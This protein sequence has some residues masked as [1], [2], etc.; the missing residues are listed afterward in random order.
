MGRKTAPR[1]GPEHDRTYPDGDHRATNISMN[2]FRAESLLSAHLAEYLRAH[3]LTLGTFNVLMILRG[4][5][6]PLC[7]WE[8]SERRLVARGTMT[9]LL[10]SLEKRGLIERR[11]HPTDRRSVHV[12]ITTKALKLLEQLLPGFFAREATLFSNLSAREK[13]T[14]ISLLAKAQDG[15][16]PST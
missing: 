15:L 3:D 13:E 16:A 7:P 9:G 5:E 11:A 4:A 1:V 10:D 6:E 12:A 8:I 14:L 2:L